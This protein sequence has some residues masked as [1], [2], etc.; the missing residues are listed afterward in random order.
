MIL[1][2]GNT[3][4]EVFAH[5]ISNTTIKV[6][7]KNKIEDDYT[8]SAWGS[9]TG[10]PL[11]GLLI[12][13]NNE[14][15]PWGCNARLKN[16]TIEA[17]EKNEADKKVYSAYV[18]QLSADYPVDVVYESSKIS[19]NDN[20]N[21]AACKSGSVNPDNYSMPITLKEAGLV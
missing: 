18:Y 17:P 10:V 5:C 6:S 21:G 9:G 8:S 20:V 15:Y 13:N 11:A 12:G 1:R 16:V 19:F 7:E 3:T 4:K 2:S 14:S